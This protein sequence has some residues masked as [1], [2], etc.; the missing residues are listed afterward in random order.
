MNDKLEKDIKSLI[1]DSVVS[2]FLIKVLR[3]SEEKIR[4]Q[5]IN[6]IVY[7][8]LGAAFASGVITFIFRKEIAELISDA[9]NITKE[10]LLRFVNMI[11]RFRK[12]K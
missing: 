4:A 6:K 7:G 9:K 1:D 12:K 8:V 3:Q 10:S 2:W 11:K 5:I